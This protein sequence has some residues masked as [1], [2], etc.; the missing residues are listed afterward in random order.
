MPKTYKGILYSINDKVTENLQG[1]LNSIYYDKDAKNLR[2]AHTSTHR[3]DGTHQILVSL[4]F[5]L[6][7]LRTLD[8][9]VR[10]G[11][12]QCRQGFLKEHSIRCVRMMPVAPTGI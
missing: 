9:I 5:I 11:Y 6:M 10:I 7:G 8:N 1:I 3:T 2:L 12:R 4:T